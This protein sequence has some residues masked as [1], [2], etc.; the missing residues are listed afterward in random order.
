[1]PR[2]AATGARV[3]LHRK[4][5]RLNKER[6]RDP[7]AIKLLPAVKPSDRSPHINAPERRHGLKP[8]LPETARKSKSR[9]EAIRKWNTKIKR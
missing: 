3:G 2:P 1:M 6:D 8:A 9:S 7:S 4:I 5:K